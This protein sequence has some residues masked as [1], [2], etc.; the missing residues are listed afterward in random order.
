MDQNPISASTDE[1]RE[2][3]G[4]RSDSIALFARVAG[5]DGEAARL[6]HEAYVSRLVG[7]ARSRLSER[8]Q[9][10]V[11]PEDVVQSVFRSFF[12]RA[13]DGQF[14]I[15]RGGEMWKLLAAITHT[16][17]LKTVE[18]HTQQKRDPSRERPIQSRDAELRLTQEPTEFE[19]IMLAEEVHE[20]MTG[21]DARRR[22]VFECRLKGMSIP[23]IAQ[24]TGRSE[25]TIRRYLNELQQS[26]QERL[27][28]SSSS[29]KPKSDSIQTD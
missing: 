9:Q 20:F 14:T 19:A 23:K 21:L 26:L 25:R 29:E 27:S 18:Y 24:Q 12:M 2:T 10:R 11:D 7:L 6:L 4:I 15:G 13:R 5:G 3:A 1:S 22:M 17:V 16:K 28:T 8:L